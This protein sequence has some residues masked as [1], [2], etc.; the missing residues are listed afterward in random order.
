MNSKMPLFATLL[1][2]IT[3]SLQATVVAQQTQGALPI[4][5]RNPNFPIPP[6]NISSD[7]MTVVDSGTLTDLDIY[8]NIPHTWTGDLELV[9]EHDGTMTT[10]VNR[11]GSPASHFGCSGDNYDVIVNDEGTDGDIETQCDNHPA[12]HGNRV[13]GDPAGAT[14]DVFD[15]HDLSG[16][17]TMTIHDHGGGD[18]GTLVE[19]CLIPN[20]V[21]L[22]PQAAVSPLHFESTLAIGESETQTLQ[23]ENLGDGFLEWISTYAPNINGDCTDPMTF[24][25]LTVRPYRGFVSLTNTRNISLI[26]DATDLD[27]GIYSATLCIETNDVSLPVIEI[28]ITLHV[29]NPTAV[30]LTTTETAPSLLLW[31]LLLGVLLLT[32]ITIYY[33]KEKATA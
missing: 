22:D 4:V 9:L 31:P 6:N 19:W 13:G 1:L 16:D 26:F 23:I 7:T 15:G 10:F 3:L 27:V 30:T 2:L 5:C 18:V 32:G 11:P 33:G 25:W 29:T 8:L 21:T 20:N 12:I 24:Y 14:L 17:W 28:P